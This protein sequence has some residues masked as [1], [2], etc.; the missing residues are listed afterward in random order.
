MNID[1]ILK[2]FNYHTD[3]DNYR[4]IILVLKKIIEHYFE[5]NGIDFITIDGRFLPF[6][7]YLKTESLDGIEAPTLVSLVTSASPK[8]IHNILNNFHQHQH[9]IDPK[10]KSLIIITLLDNSEI[11]KI[12]KNKEIGTSIQILGKSFFNK[13]INSD[14]KFTKNLIQ[15]FDN[16]KFKE[17]ISNKNDKMWREDREKIIADLISKYKSGNFSLLLGAGIS[18]DANLPSWEQLIS[19]LLVKSFSEHQDINEQKYEEITI[20]RVANQFKKNQ[21][22]SALLSARYL[23]KSLTRNNET[24][25]NFR[26]II[27]EVLYKSKPIKRDSKLI[28]TIGR[29]CIPT[30]MRAHIDSI[31]TYNFDDL[32]E[33]KLNLLNL[34]FHVIANSIESYSIQE[35]PIYHVHGFIPEDLE[36]YKNATNEIVFSEDGYHKIYSDP[37]HWSNLVQLTHLREKSCLMIGLSLDDPNIRRLM[38]IVSN[39]SLSPRHYAL[40]QRVKLENLIPEQPTSSE[41]ALASNFLKSHHHLQES[42]FRDLGVNI[43][44]YEEYKEIPDI[45]EILLN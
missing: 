45:L 17:I 39:P 40:I 6:D 21:F 22:N 8:L 33:Q 30:R 15:N 28:E 43:I 35:I 37:Y 23:K 42:I 41:T 14:L 12:I 11:E 44:W 31:I 38:D 34:K 13:I 4:N 24:N 36:K 25:E 32:I 2:E 3:L 9:S 27:H 19:S 29:L 7:Y 26:N 20:E 10:P 5:V 1:E 16:L 18:C